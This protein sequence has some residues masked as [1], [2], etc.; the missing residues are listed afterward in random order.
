MYCTPL[1][2]FILLA[3][4]SQATIAYNKLGYKM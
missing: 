1:P 2:P 3:W 4:Y